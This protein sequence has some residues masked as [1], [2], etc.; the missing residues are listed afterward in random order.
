MSFFRPMLAP[1]NSPADTPSFFD[2]FVFPQLVSAKI[3]GIR[4]C[5]RPVH[6]LDY[7]SLDN[8][9]IIGTESAV[10][11]RTL[12]RLRSKQVQEQYSDCLYCDGELAYDPTASDCLN[13]TQSYVRSAN[14]FCETLGY[15]AF[16]WTEDSMARRPYYIRLEHLQRMASEY[17]VSS[18]Q[19][20]P[21]V[22]VNSVDE[23]LRVEEQYLMEGYEGVMVRNPEGIYK[24]NRATYR[25]NLIY[26]LKRFTDREAI[27]LGF[28]EGE[29]NL[30]EKVTD[31]RGFSKR[32]SAKDGKVPNGRVGKIIVR[33]LH[34]SDETFI[35]APGVL[36]LPQRE[37]MLKNQERFIGK[38]CTYRF[39][40]YG[41]KNERRFARFVA[42]RE[43]WD[44]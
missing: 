11:S 13:V 25:E 31:A 30:N 19:V 36:K 43:K 15:Y 21:Q 29:E 16:D 42:F 9:I 27:I 26:K 23:L 3:D 14:K 39:F 41:I 6:L 5:P 12:E 37:F 20:I 34:G 22:A 8:P 32:S 1:L 18:V 10:L 40:N 17:N 7:T 2:D 38:I 33:D 4:G 24:H 28:I 35:I 44:M